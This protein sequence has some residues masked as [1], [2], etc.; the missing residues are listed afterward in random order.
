MSSP[1]TNPKIRKDKN[2]TAAVIDLEPLLTYSEKHLFADLLAYNKEVGLDM[3]FR[4]AGGWVRDKIMGIP[5]NDIDIAIDRASG[6]LF[7]TG[8][9]EYLKR[10]KSKVRGYHVIPYNHEKAKHLETASLLYYGYSI[11]FVAL[12]TEEY[13]DSRIPNVRMGT[14]LEDAERRDLTINALFYNINRGQV[15][16]YTGKG[17]AD[18][19]G[20]VV[21]TPLPARET[22]LDDPLRVLRVLRFAARLG[23]TIVPEILTA[24]EDQDLLKKMA[25]VVSRERIGQEL[26]KTLSHPNYGLALGIMAQYRLTTIIFPN[27]PLNSTHLNVT[28]QYCQH[29]RQLSKNPPAGHPL[30]QIPNAQLYFIPLF[31]ILQHTLY[32]PPIQK[33]PISG[34]T[35]SEDLKWTKK[36][37]ALVIHLAQSLLYLS[38]NLDMYSHSSHSNSTTAP[39]QSKQYTLIK[40]A[41]YIKDSLP[42]ALT[43]YDLIQQSQTSTSPILHPIS[44]NAIQQDLTTYNYQT[45]WQSPPPLTFQFLQRHLK[46]SLKDTRV[47]HEECTILSIIHHTT[48]SETLLQLLSQLYPTITTTNTT[49]TKPP[50]I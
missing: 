47:Y 31:A 12:R 32:L 1:I 25:R 39:T 24:L 44:I 4:V 16:D 11:D 41:R 5:C 46:A 38:A 15:E 34:R 33:E 7:A 35:V 14:P 19:Q 22:F 36:E 17:I 6:S 50:N 42:L 28:T 3:V 40:M 9:V 2:L 13:A 43:I 37:K 48:D 26:K 29:H 20:R 8:F 21:R 23:F 10:K 30:L 27:I 49:T 45:V 18:I